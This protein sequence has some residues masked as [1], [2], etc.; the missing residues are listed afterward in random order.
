MNKT[1]LI[2]H[3]RFYGNQTLEEVFRIS[4]RIL[5]VATGKIIGYNELNRTISGFILFRK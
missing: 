3:E 1:K 4:I 2:I 5:P